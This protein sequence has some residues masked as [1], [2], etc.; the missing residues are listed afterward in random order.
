MT[1]EKTSGITKHVGGSVH[2]TRSRSH[3][4]SGVAQIL[5]RCSPMT[6]SVAFLSVLVT[7]VVIQFASQH[8]LASQN[9]KQEVL[10]PGGRHKFE[11]KLE[12]PKKQSGS[13]AKSS[14][15]TTTPRYHVVF[16]TSCT[17][18]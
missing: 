6:M 7:L 10:F 1:K 17:R 2:R 15:P 3:H 16:S 9:N 8:S 12:Y 14:S 11:P 4:G 13:A 18:K 5:F